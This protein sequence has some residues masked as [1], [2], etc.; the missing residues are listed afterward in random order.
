MM[1]S[2]TDVNHAGATVDVIFK[3]KNARNIWKVGYHIVVLHGRHHH[4]SLGISQK[5]GE[6]TWSTDQLHMLPIM[7][8]DEASVKQVEAIKLSKVCSTL[9]GTVRKVS[10][11]LDMENACSSTTLIHLS[12]NTV[13][14][15]WTKLLKTISMT[16]CRPSTCSQV[17]T[18][19]TFL[20]LGL[21]RFVWSTTSWSLFSRCWASI[22]AVWR[23]LVCLISTALFCPSR[24][25]MNLNWWITLQTALSKHPT[26]N[27]TSHA[28]AF[29]DTAKLAQ[30]HLRNL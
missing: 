16:K 10:S 27:I 30:T 17:C 7:V 12:L 8:R 25:A 22:L 19:F 11:I 9:S 3:E 6:H 1:V 13:Q 20:I 29:W 26:N 23:V 4:T 18:P 24:G 14:D 5:A 21:L 2:S 28:T 15:Y